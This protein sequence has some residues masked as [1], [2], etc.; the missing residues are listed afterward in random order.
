MPRFKL[1]LEY[2]G[3]RYY[4]WQIQKNVRT[5][6]GEIAN[7]AHKVFKTSEF[8]LMGSGR[9]DAGVHALMQVAHLDVKT[10][11]GP[12]II[13]MKLNDELPADVNILD[14]EKVD[15]EFHARYHADAR[16]YLYQISRRRTA[17]GKR[18]VWWIKDQLD[19]KRMQESLH[20]FVG[21]KNF[22]SFTEDDPEE[23]STN[24]LIESAE[25][26]EDGGLILIRI[27]GSHFI[28]K[29]VRRIVGVLVEVGRGNLTHDDIKR[30]LS[31]KSEEPAQYTAPPSG[32]FLERV[33]YKGES[34]SKDLHPM[35]SISPLPHHKAKK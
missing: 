28:R 20:L 8:E 21:M 33:L 5:V 17:F 4:G 12:E 25:L 7:A 18:Y 26:K 23:K 19:T 29:M 30:Y 3:T 2:E 24:V 10:V 22:F 35:L 27:R 34:D 13:R 9:T 6:Q 31:T 1:T 16:I 15:A 14:V 11:L 32:L